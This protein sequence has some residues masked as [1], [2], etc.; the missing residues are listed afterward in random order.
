MKAFLLTLLMGAVTNIVY[1]SASPGVSLY[2]A[3]AGGVYTISGH[4]GRDQSI[5]S[6]VA[7]SES[8]LATSCHIDSAGKGFKVKIDGKFY[9]AK[10]KYA[11][12][13]QDLC[14]LAVDQ[15]K[16]KP[17]TMLFSNQVSIGEDVFAIANP[18]G[19]EKSI[20]RGIISNK[21]QVGHASILQTDVTLEAGSSGGGLFNLDGKLIGIIYAGHRLKNVGYVMPTEWVQAGIEKSR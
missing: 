5:G 3:V 14:L 16:F 19:I 13:K 4:D 15:H 17:V 11:N 7:V 10:L 1:A 9:P 12:V 21:R 6:A 18:Y 2:Q 20:T 8:L